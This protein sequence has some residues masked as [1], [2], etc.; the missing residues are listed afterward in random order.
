LAEGIERGTRRDEVA[1]EEK[2]SRCRL[3][4]CNYIRNNRASKLVP[5]DMREEVDRAPGGDGS[6]S[7]RAG[8]RTGVENLRERGTLGGRR[9]ADDDG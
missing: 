6:K 2:V 7:K 5:A 9:W 8:G 4:Y 1:K 3:A